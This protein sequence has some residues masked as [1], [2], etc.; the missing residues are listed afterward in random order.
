MFFRWL[1]ARL[2]LVAYISLCNAYSRIHPSA[3]YLYIQHQQPLAPP[4]TNYLNS[5]LLTQIHHSK[6][7]VNKF[8]DIVSGKLGGLYG[9]SRKRNFHLFDAQAFFDFIQRQGFTLLNLDQ[10]F[11]NRLNKGGSF[12]LIFAV[13]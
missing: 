7:R 8:A 12:S 9:R 13:F 2:R 10:T 11:L 3:L 5:I 6:R 4:H 1:P